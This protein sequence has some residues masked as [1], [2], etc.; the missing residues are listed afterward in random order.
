[1]LLDRQVEPRT[2]RVNT[3]L[4]CVGSL[5]IMSEILQ[6]YILHCKQFLIP[7]YI[8]FNCNSVCLFIRLAFATITTDSVKML[9]LASPRHLRDCIAA[10]QFLL[11]S[12]NVLWTRA[13]TA[14]EHLTLLQTRPF[15]TQK[16][17]LQCCLSISS[18]HKPG[19]FSVRSSL[20]PL[21][22][23]CEYPF[24]WPLFLWPVWFDDPIKSLK[25]W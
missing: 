5:C 14:G 13:F 3:H 22:Y 11:Q 12:L 19:F 7:T 17:R 23:L 2:G 6:L 25:A 16:A 24:F 15:W 20:I 1:M 8:S 21:R 10:C 4:N 9:L 18:P